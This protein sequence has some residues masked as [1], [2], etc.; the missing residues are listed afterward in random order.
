M[1]LPPRFEYL[2][3][4]WDPELINKSGSWDSKAVVK[5]KAEAWQQQVTS[6]QSPGVL[7]QTIDQHNLIITYGFV[8]GVVA[9]GKSSISVLDWG[10][11]FGWYYN[12]AK[13]LFPSLKIDYHCRDVPTMV[14]QGRKLNAEILFHKD[15]RC[16]NRKY[17]LVMANG[18]VSYSPEW[19]QTILNLT[20]CSSKYIYLS[21]DALHGKAPTFAVLDRAYQYDNKNGHNMLIWFFNRSEYLSLVTGCGFSLLREFKLLNFSHEVINAPEQNRERHGFL[22]HRDNNK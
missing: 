2:P 15:D 18:S 9:Q 8:V 6:I 22:F 4:G 1:A 3:Q 17:D 21:K 14:A 5:K 12:I 16:F 13:S 7:A 20:N 10:G 19:K 11:G